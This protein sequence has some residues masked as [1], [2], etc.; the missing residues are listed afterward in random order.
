LKKIRLR[1]LIRTI[2]AP[3]I[4]LEF[5]RNFVNPASPEG[6]AAENPK[7][8]KPNSPDGTESLYG[9]VGILRTG[10]KKPTVVANPRR[11]KKLVTPDHEKTEIFNHLFFLDQE[12][13]FLP[14]TGSTVGSH[15]PIILF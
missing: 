5:V 9:C 4:P 10:R 2:P 6:V 15:P 1:F 11:K 14:L 13:E 7:K 12:P 3:T 8:R